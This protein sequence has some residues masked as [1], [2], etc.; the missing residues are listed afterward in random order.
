MPV[1]KTVILP[2]NEHPPDTSEKSMRNLAYP[3][4]W[5]EI[6]EYIGF[7]AFFKPFSGGGWKSVYRVDEPGG[8]LQAYH[9]TGQ[10]VMMLQEEIVF[11]EYFR[12]YCLGRKDVHIMQ[13]DPRNPH[14]ERYVKDG[15]ADRRRRCSS[16][17]TTTCLKLN[18]ALGY[19]FNT[20]EFAVRDGIPYAIDFCNPAPDADVAVGRRGE[21]RVGRRGGGQHGDP[22]RAGA[23]RRPGQPDLGRVRQPARRCRQTAAASPAEQERRPFRSPRPRRRGARAVMQS[24]REECAMSDPKWFTLGIEEEF[25]IIDPETRE[26]RSHVQDILEEGKLV[27]KERVK[28]EM[29]QSVVEIGTGICRDIARGRASEVDRA[30]DASSSGSPE[31][32]HDHRASAGT[33]PFSHWADQQIT[34]TRATTRSSRTCSRWRGPT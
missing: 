7:P 29:H 16:A 28:P 4:D 15:A 13:Y 20:L 34:E 26:L 9:E 21:L 30:A 33:H 22:P 32:R 1:P 27:L 2:S 14:H 6:F 8:V 31:E 18:R 3:L 5:E 23:G 10:L 12:C 24:I 19:D 17:C 11:K 25:Q